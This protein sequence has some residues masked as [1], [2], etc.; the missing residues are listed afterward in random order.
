MTTTEIEPRRRATLI[1]FEGID[2]SGKTTLSNA[3]ATTLR[4][5]GL[6]VSHV[7]EGGTFASM[8][9]QAIRELG[10]DSRNLAMTPLAELFVYLARE[11]Q[12]LQEATLPALAEADVVIADRFFYTAEL[13]ATCGRTLTPAEVEPVV[14]AA[15]TGIQPDLVV[16]VDV[17]PHVARARRKVSKIGKVDPR[18]PSRK[19]LAGVGLQHR[20]REGYRARA[21]REPQRWIVVDNTEA[22]LQTVIDGLV[23]A[24]AAART[25]DVA[26][27]RACLPAPIVRAPADGITAAA[28][29]FGD[30]IDRRATREPALAAYLLAGLAGPGWDERRQALAAQVPLV[31]AAGVGNQQD[32]VSWALRR[33]LEALA[34]GAIAR[35]YTSS[36]NPLALTPVAPERAAEAA[37]RLRA[38]VAQVPR[39]VASGLWGRDDALAWELR[40]QLGGDELV[41]S[42]AG[43]GGARAWAIRAAWLTARGGDDAF[44]QFEAAHLACGA[45]AGLADA[46][47]WRWRLAARNA[48]PVAALASVWG[49]FDERAWKWRHKSLARAPKPVLS[50]LAASDDP[51]AWAM[52]QDTL[53]RCPEALDSIRGLDTDAAWALRDAG[54][55]PWP[56]AAVK[57]LGPLLPSDRGRDLLTRQLVRFPDNLALWRAAAQAL[58]RGAVDA[59]D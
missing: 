28:A 35:S 52:R 58:A 7:R 31:V 20:L 15:T 39:D 10:R 24:V 26:A 54:A 48:A 9:T 46:E 4:A 37:D 36:T 22:E 38:L 59:E 33:A 25:T 34:P 40:D 8:V 11:I 56:A 1:V 45:V 44:D 12:L 53:A 14:A 3:V 6:R 55:E 16:L 42:V 27:A 43:V 21:A 17:D 23:A 51:R 47:A 50:S 5:Q 19:G 49:V 18:P 32:E 41:R 57:S 30:W 2:G 13:L 29:A